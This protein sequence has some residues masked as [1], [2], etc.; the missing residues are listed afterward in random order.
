MFSRRENREMLD[1][2]ATLVAVGSTTQP[3]GLSTV[4]R[5][6]TRF[7][8]YKVLRGTFL[9]YHTIYRFITAPASL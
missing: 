4:P 7:V 2:F 3:V 8:Q 6:T 9:C 1:H 5:C